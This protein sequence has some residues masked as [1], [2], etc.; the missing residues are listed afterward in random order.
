MRTTSLLSQ[1]SFY[2][3]SS[4]RITHFNRL[5]L[6]HYCFPSNFCL[7]WSAFELSGD[8]NHPMA[9]KSQYSISY[10]SVTASPRHSDLE[11]EP[12][13]STREKEP[14]QSTGKPEA[15]PLWNTSDLF[16]V[17]GSFV[18][19][20]LA[21]LVIFP[22]GTLSWQ[23]GFNNQ[24]III[25]FLLSIMHLLLR[26][27]APTFFLIL[28]SRWGSSH[29]QNYDAILRNGM[30]LSQTGTIWRITIAVIT[31]LPLGLSVG[32]KRFMGGASSISINSPWPASISSYGI[33]LPPLGDFTT[34]NNSIY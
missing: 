1:V 19:L 20:A 7:F 22:N 16:V 15:K 4:T 8:F 33:A 34:M 13:E 9:P 31:F 25:G 10:T 30:F 24:I 17:L 6:A 32:Y 5:L 29:L 11:L 18:C 21:I 26:T 3:P 14:V 12:F 28:E 27:I 23:L 2:S